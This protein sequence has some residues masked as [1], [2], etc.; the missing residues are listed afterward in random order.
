MYV[1]L[2]LRKIDE[3]IQA[4]NAILDL[5]SQ[6]QASDGIPSLEEKCIRAIVG[7]ALKTFHAAKD[8][9]G[10]LDAARRTLSRTSALLERVKS[11]S[12]PEPWL[13]ETIAFFHQGIG[14]EGSKEVYENLMKEYRALQSIPGWE[15]DDSQVK[16]ACEVVT[17][18]V[19]I[20][21]RVG[22]KESLSKSKFLVRGVIQKV[23]KS[24]M[25]PT[26]VPVCIGQ[27]ESLLKELEEDI[28]SN[29]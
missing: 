19:D 18:C 17:Q 29:Q 6:K 7:G 5:R 24:R 13:Y 28:N 3:A 1:C 20:Q 26:N 22:T 27:L 8:N 23:Q 10:V 2:D 14:G 9:Q 12:N 25:D 11:T 21:R 15:K 16:K 4:A